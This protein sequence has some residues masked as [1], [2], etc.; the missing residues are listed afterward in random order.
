M[1]LGGD[2]GSGEG[3]GGGVG[4]GDLCPQ[5]AVAN[6]VAK[7]LFCV[8]KPKDKLTSPVSAHT[9]SNTLTYHTIILIICIS[10]YHKRPPVPPAALQ[11]R[12]EHCEILRPQVGRAWAKV[13]RKRVILKKRKLAE[14][15]Q[16]GIKTLKGEEGGN[17]DA[18]AVGGIILDG[19]EVAAKVIDTAMEASA[20]A[21]ASAADAYGSAGSDP[22]VAIL[23]GTTALTLKAFGAYQTE[24]ITA[25]S[26]ADANWW[27]SAFS[28]AGNLAGITGSIIAACF[29]PTGL[30]VL[31]VVASVASSAGMEG[32][33]WQERTN[34]R[35]MPT[36]NDERTNQTNRV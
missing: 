8:H 25:K 32:I 11:S 15:F 21:L 10:T 18:V 13:Y 35:E 17:A 33:I 30:S 3:G 5:S 28:R 34:V 24:K 20:D 31:S 16:K 19:A 22:V 4:G 29:D 2:P 6:V 14:R 23:V 7:L 12:Y 9:H 27:S 26:T 1:S 36:C